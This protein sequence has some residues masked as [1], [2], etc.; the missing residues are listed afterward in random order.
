MLGI[1]IGTE[2]R[3]NLEN[4]FNTDKTAVDYSQVQIIGN[5][6]VGLLDTINKRFQK[7][8]DLYKELKSLDW[9]ENE[10]DYSQCLQD[11]KKAPTDTSEAMI[12]TIMWQWESD[13]VASQCPAV[14]LAP[15]QPCTEL[16]EAELRINDNE[17]IHGNTYSEI[18]RLSFDIPQDVLKEMLN[19]T[20]T[21]RR[22]EVIGKALK[23]VKRSSATINYM[24]E[25]EGVEPTQEKMYHDMILFYFCMWVLERVQFM[26]SFAITFTICQSGWF[27]AIG[28]AVKKICQD[29]FEVHS[30][31]RKEVLKELRS[32]PI[33]AVV[34]ESLKPRLS[35]ILDEV[36]DCEIN[37]VYADVF[38]N[39]NKSL[40]GTNADLV[41]QWTLFCAKPIV[42]EL[43]LDSKHK[44][45]TKNP[46]PHLEEWIDITKNQAAPQEQDNPAY[47][48]NIVQRDDVGV[49]F[50]I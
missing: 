25:C 10:F 30:E 32:H 1:Q 40:V 5:G 37:W 19:K 47:K 44:F 2:W 27:Q 39:G 34:F 8:W 4:I 12:K 48:V 21:Y 18:V 33:G 41:S 3:V 17:S 16:W 14:I 31:F 6:D 36:L 50:E 45:P 29:E 15:Y 26:A 22:L 24:R 43:K 28:M 13:S 46:M 9:D 20:E 23:E 35:K 42:H 11:F 49:I 7:I 38:D